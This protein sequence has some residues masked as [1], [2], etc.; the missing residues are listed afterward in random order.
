MSMAVPE[1]ELVE[2]LLEILGAHVVVH[3]NQPSFEE[4]PGILYEADMDVAVD[5]LLLMNDVLMRT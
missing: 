2:I 3:P 5:P 1:R 4:T